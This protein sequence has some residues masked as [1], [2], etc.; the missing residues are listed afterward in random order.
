M[1]RFCDKCG[2]LVSGKVKFCPFCGGKMEFELSVS[3]TLDIDNDNSFWDELDNSVPQTVNA[4]E[5]PSV[6]A[7]STVSADV[8]MAQ[9]KKQPPVQQNGGYIPQNTQQSAFSY[10]AQNT[11]S[12]EKLTTAQWIG[13]LLLSVCL[14]FISIILLVVWGFGKDT[15]EPRRS[16]ARAM[17]ILMPV[18]YFAVFIGLGVF[19]SILEL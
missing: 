12:T 16:F 2:S 4:S 9:T 13:T 19:C 5:T 7:N 8:P 10:L 18:I 1:E 3:S 17:L 15:K 6:T 11:N 14:G